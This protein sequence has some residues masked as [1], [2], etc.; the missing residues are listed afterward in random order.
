MRLRNRVAAVW[1]ALSISLLGLLPT[2]TNA[3]AD[4]TERR[5]FDPDRC[6]EFV[7]RAPILS[8]PENWK[9]GKSNP[10]EWRLEAEKEEEASR[11]REPTRKDV[12]VVFAHGWLSSST[13][14]KDR[15]GAFS[16]AVDM[17]SDGAPKL[18][19][20]GVRA[21]KVSLIDWVQD[22]TGTVSYT[23][24]YSKVNGRWVTD[25]DIGSKLARGLECLA[26]TYLRPTVV[27][28]HSMGGLAVREAASRLDRPV[29]RV[30]SHVLTIGTPNEGSRV[31]RHVGSAIGLTKKGISNAVTNLLFDKTLGTNADLYDQTGKGLTGV[32]FVDAFEGEAG[33]A[34]RAGSPELKRLPKMPK[35]VDVHVVAGDMRIGGLA[36]FNHKLEGP[37][38]VGDGIVSKSSALSGTPEKNQHVVKCS[39]LTRVVKAESRKGRIHLNLDVDFGDRRG[40]ASP[41]KLPCFHTNL[42]RETGAALKLNDV[43]DK[44]VL[45]AD[46]D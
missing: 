14:N 15:T 11:Q 37:I 30:L 21:R 9:L 24:D 34:L 5:G 16:K 26:E 42:T 13:H 23:F 35:E 3:A 39:G 27:V 44:A 33:K 22:H 1:I 36:L 20:M 32:P 19:S 25:K 38:S 41:N 28:A 8:A 10:E 7:S 6:S 46:L 12:P 40:T 2:A 29:N 18:I 4:D 31:A 43:L 17:G 45:Y